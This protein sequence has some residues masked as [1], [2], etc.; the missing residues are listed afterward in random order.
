MKKQNA[1][2]FDYYTSADEKIDPV[3]MPK[4][5]YHTS[6]VSPQ[7]AIENLQ[8]ISKKINEDDLFTVAY[9]A[10]NPHLSEEDRAK[11]KLKMEELV[12]SNIT[13]GMEFNTI[14]HRKLAVADPE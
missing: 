3:V 11:F 1:L 5:D 4:I 14:L 8:K 9:L 12:K 2:R 10:N 7:I 6:M 13:C